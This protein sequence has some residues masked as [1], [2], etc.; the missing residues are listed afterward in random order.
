MA[1]MNTHLLILPLLTA[2]LSYA[3]PA[4][5]AALVQTDE[6][7]QDLSAELEKIRAEAGAP[8]V[9]AVAVQDGTVVAWAVAGVRAQGSS[10]KL[11]LGDPMH[12]GSC[13]K[14]MTSTLLACLIDEGKLRS[15]STI[16]EV[17]P[18]LAKRID[19]SYHDVTVDMLLHH[20][21]G[22]AERRRPE[23]MAAYGEL[24]SIEGSAAEIRLELLARVMHL[25]QL[26][27]ADGA[28]DYSNFGYMT[29]GAM[30]EAVTG[31]TWE[32]L[33]AEKVFRPLGMTSAGLGSPAGDDVPVG[34]QMTD[35]VLVAL[36]PG[37]DGELPVCMGPAGLAHSNLVDWARF[38]TDQMRGERGEGEL[39]KSDTYVQLHADTY[40]SGYAA[41]WGIAKHSLSWSEPTAS[42]RHNGS[43]GTWY[44]MVKALPEWELVVVSAANCADGPAERAT[45]QAELLL[46]KALGF[47]D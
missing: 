35:G 40:G 45:T 19:K 2:S 23:V 13:T 4:S 24:D 39:L 22:I 10:A 1:P 7:T 11:Q 32:A 3:A 33:M 26:P 43:D 20:R 14:A 8:G 44:S 6:G 47:A 37:P 41:G 30:A 5:P 25:P 38:V 28:F 46:L 29:A 12:L 15:D 34:H 42:W 18:E 17:L 36:P 16:G 21:A 31:K 27:P 9:V